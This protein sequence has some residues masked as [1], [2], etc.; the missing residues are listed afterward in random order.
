MR[1]RT[2]CP[3]LTFALL[4]NVYVILPLTAGEFN[5]TGLNFNKILTKPGFV[6]IE[7]ETSHLVRS[8]RQ[9][10]VEFGNSLT[11]SENEQVNRRLAQIT[12]WK[13]LR[14]KIDAKSSR[15]YLVPK[16]P[17]DEFVQFPRTLLAGGVDVL[18]PLPMLSEPR[19]PWRLCGMHCAG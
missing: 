2:S 19:G 15:S 16:P 10:V 17:L 4:E 6:I 13:C 18:L 11:S 14:K 5:Q 9:A 3:D 7:V 12:D 1:P 8:R